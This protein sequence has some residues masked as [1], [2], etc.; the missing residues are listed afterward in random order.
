VFTADTLIEVKTREG[1]V[2]GVFYQTYPLTLTK[3]HESLLLRMAT[4]DK[5]SILPDDLK[6]EL[7]NVCNDFLEYDQ[8]EHSKYAVS[9]VI[10]RDRD[11]HS[12]DPLV[13][14]DLQYFD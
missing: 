7:R 14:L 9:L 11:D 1:L 12:V 4:D 13:T 3:D 10:H 8:E 6:L 5:T 2:G